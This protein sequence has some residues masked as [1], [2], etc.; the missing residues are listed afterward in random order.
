MRRRLKEEAIKLRKAG[1]TYVQI[2][3]DLKVRIPKS[4]L[5]E[6]CRDIP[7]PSGYQRKIRE[8]NLYT[9]QKARKYARQAIEAKKQRKI[10]AIRNNNSRFSGIITDKDIAKVAL[11]SLYLGEGFKNPKRGSLAFG[12][13][14]AFIISFFLYLLRIS[15]NIDE[16]KFRCTV[17]CRADQDAEFLKK[18]W[19][20]IT[21]IPLAQ[22]YKSLIDPRT[23]GKPSK[24]AD[25]KGVCKIDYFS[26][27]IFH[28]LLELPKIIFK[29][30]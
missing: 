14:D 22:F 28:E 13:S 16:G 4:T 26:A 6:W 27:D 5:S 24:K 7:L 19:S 21:N 17:Q 8:Y 23:V 20:G 25:Y 11:V 15:Y 9:L 10:N 12:N 3:E 2:C 1:K 18:Y 29:G 30:P